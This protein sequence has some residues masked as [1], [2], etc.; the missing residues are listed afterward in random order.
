MPLR[1]QPREAPARAAPYP[2]NL[3]GPKPPAE[4]PPQ[5][6]LQQAPQPQQ[7]SDQASAPSRSGPDEES[8][9]V[10]Q[11]ALPISP[12]DETSSSSP[13]PLQTETDEIITWA[14]EP[15]IWPTIG[16]RR[17]SPQEIRA[18]HRDA[19]HQQIEREQRLVSD[20]VRAIGLLESQYDTM[21][22]L[23]EVGT[24][25]ALDIQLLEVIQGQVPSLHICTSITYGWLHSNRYLIRSCVA[26]LRSEGRYASSGLIS[27]STN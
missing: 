8:E 25:P 5:W 20:N 24:T 23:L 16:G 19:L 26:V 14:T 13:E 15:W 2:T 17:A 1:E 27:T 9:V 12:P 3:R 7:Q 4:P 6:L 21:A 18:A 22:R 11:V 10:P